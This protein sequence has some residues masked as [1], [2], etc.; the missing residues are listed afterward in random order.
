MA[1]SLTQARP[2]G[3]QP[4]PQTA[5]QRRKLRKYLP[6]QVWVE[7]AAFNHPQTL[8]MLNNLPSIPVDVVENKTDLNI[9]K[10]DIAKHHLFISRK[11]ASLK[12]WPGV[13]KAKDAT[14]LR[15]LE[16]VTGS[17]I[18]CSYL[19]L[20]EGII[21]TVSVNIEDT[22]SQLEKTFKQSPK[23]IFRV[24][25][26]ESADSLSLDHI[27]EF[28]PLLVRFFAEQP[29]ALLELKTRTANVEHLLDLSHRN[30]TIVSWNLS[31]QDLIYSEERKT[32]NLDERLL[33][34]QQIARAGY[35]MGFYLGP[36]VANQQVE[37]HLATYLQLID[38]LFMEISPH[39]VAW[40]YLQLFQYPK[41][42]EQAAL[43]RF[44]RTRIFNGEFV[45]QGK[46]MHYPRF[47]REECYRPLV[48]KL[49]EKI[50]LSKIHFWNEAL[51]MWQK[52]DP[53]LQSEEQL[54]A[55]LTASEKM[56][57]QTHPQV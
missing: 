9:L 15:S 38:R 26:G 25:T 13:E 56:R 51:P 5:P 22:L 11:G 50:P 54:M 34:A 57:Q 16:L 48:A 14:G 29:N 28:S 44:P 12:P 3:F 37:M 40:V 36:I 7:R 23:Q 30:R 2:I 45:P 42:L 33:A 27:T 32:S 47:V 20:S 10:V 39:Q 1:T 8:R 18:D 43:Q 55:R 17:Q 53:R 4:R 41:G 21:P 49:S 24:S 31:P 52:F 35:F 6:D 19:P 46:T